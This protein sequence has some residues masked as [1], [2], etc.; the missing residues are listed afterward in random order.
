GAALPDTVFLFLAADYLI[1]D[2]SL[3]SAV[4]RIEA[5]A[6]AVLAGTLPL[7]SAAAAALARD[8]AHAPGDA[9]TLPARPLVRHALAGFG[10]PGAP[11]FQHGNRLFWRRDSSTL[12]GRFYLLHMLAIRP[13]VADF[14]VGAPC[15]YSFVP[16]LCPSGRIDILTDSDDYLAAEI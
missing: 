7:A 2:G 15:D 16:E 10:D 11:L 8:H 5:G 6:S 4:R 13:E 1:A 12:L 14:V 3:R 9:L